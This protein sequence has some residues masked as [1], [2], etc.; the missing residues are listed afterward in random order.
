VARLDALL[1][2]IGELVIDRARLVQLGNNVA[3]RFGDHRVIGD[4][5]DRLLAD[6]VAKK[7]IPVRIDTAR[8]QRLLQNSDAEVRDIA[9]KQGKQVD[10]IIEGKDTELDRSVIEEIG[11]PLLHLIRNSVDHG[12]EPPEERIAAGKAPV[13]KLR[14]SAHHADSHIVI[15]LDDDGRGLPLTRSSARWPTRSDHCRTCRP[16]DRR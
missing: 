16:H 4:L 13:G 3:E 14:L 10:F 2:Q 8:R 5:A 15:T 7:E 12:L 11:D 1:S 6:A 9:A